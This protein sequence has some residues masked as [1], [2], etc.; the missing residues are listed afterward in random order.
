MYDGMLWNMRVFILLISV[1]LHSWKIKLGACFSENIWFYQHRSFPTHNLDP[2]LSDKNNNPHSFEEKCLSIATPAHK[3]C[4][5]WN[6][7]VETDKK[8]NGC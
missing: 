5:Y 2:H 1:C 6:K 3:Y 4:A 7:T 8:L